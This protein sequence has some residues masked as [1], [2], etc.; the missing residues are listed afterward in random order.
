[1][2]FYRMLLLSISYVGFLKRSKYWLLTGLLFTEREIQSCESYS[3]LNWMDKGL[4][5]IAFFILI[6]ISLVLIFFFFFLIFDH[7]NQNQLEE[8]AQDSGILE[9]YDYLP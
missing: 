4:S 9:I 8:V 5:I 7:I 2:P 3:A 6:I 1:M